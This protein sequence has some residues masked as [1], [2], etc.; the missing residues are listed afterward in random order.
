VIRD[1]V[2]GREPD[3][4][5]EF[6]SN[7]SA[8]IEA[9]LA[10]AT[11]T[12]DVIQALQNKGLSDE[13][14]TA[15]AE[16]FL[17]MALNS[18]VV[19]FRLLISGLPVPAGCQARHF[20]ESVAMA[21]MIAHRDLD[22][23]ERFHAKPLEYPVQKAIHKANRR[24]VRKVLDLDQDGWSGLMEINGFFDLMAHASAFSAAAVN[25]LDGTERRFLG[26]G[27]DDGKRELYEK[28]MTLLTSA[29]DRLREVV[30]GVETFL[31]D[32]SGAV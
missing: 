11:A 17:F 22:V 25:H 30:P 3:V 15:W 14:R 32:A 27:F 16:A 28:M 20:G 24:K 10:S 13:P 29:S 9:F 12:L 21:L 8:E 2:I 19:S 6:L 31:R 4:Q 18:L 5:G 23:F 7:Y 26:A 1:V